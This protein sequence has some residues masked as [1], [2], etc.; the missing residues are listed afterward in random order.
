MTGKVPDARH[1]NRKGIVMIKQITPVLAIVAALLSGAAMPAAAQEPSKQ[2][3]GGTYNW[4]HPKLGFV[5]VDRATGAM[6]HSQGLARPS[7]P[8]DGRSG[9]TKDTSRVIE[10]P[11]ADMPQV[12]KR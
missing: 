11:V 1:S 5:K 10:T 7:A 3:A 8:A 4:L 9:Q 2:Q 6:V 12:K